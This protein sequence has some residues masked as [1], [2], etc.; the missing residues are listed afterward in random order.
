LKRRPKKKRATEHLRDQTTLERA[1]QQQEAKIADLQSKLERL[2]QKV[3][4]L[5]QMLD[6]ILA[7]GTKKARKEGTEKK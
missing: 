6:E 4:K 1:Q 2:D 3:G 5:Q 7:S